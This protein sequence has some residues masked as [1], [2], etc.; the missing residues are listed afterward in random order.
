MSKARVLIIT[1]KEDLTVDF[2][3]E[4]LKR[5]GVSYY[6]FN[7]EDIGSTIK[8]YLDKNGYSLFDDRKSLIVKIKDFSSV[9]FR[10]P[11][12]PCPAQGLTSGERLFCITEISTYLEGIYRSLAPSFWLNSVFDM[13]I[14]ENK[15]YQ[16]GVAKEIGFLIPDFC[17]SN[18]PDACIEFIEEHH[19]CIF[20]PLKS[21]LIEE[22]EDLGK[23][24]YTTRVDQNFIDRISTIGSFPVYIQRQI[25]KNSDI[26][27]TVVGKKIFGAK[28]ISQDSELSEVDWR[29]SDS[30]LPHEKIEIPVE[31]GD[32]CLRLCELFKLNFAAIDFILDD[33]GRFWFLEINPNGQWAWIEGLLGYPISNEISGLLASGGRE[34]A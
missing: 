33:F 2:V 34:G 28:I 12:L 27:V 16:L 18:D 15:P 11:K 23:V 31:V 24:I 10:R 7:T 4:A 25:V 17:I 19:C 20:K 6:R 9:Y 8:V 29:R 14:I 5:R 32:M 26:R 3:I 13:R 22:S 21:G 30:M 1:N